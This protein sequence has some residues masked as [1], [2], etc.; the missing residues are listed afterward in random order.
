MTAG[1]EIDD[2]AAR[3]LAR[4]LSTASLRRAD[5]RFKSPAA[6]TTRLAESPVEVADSRIVLSSFRNCPA[7]SVTK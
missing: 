3:M 7:S 6:S 1:A 2:Q 5:C 4:N